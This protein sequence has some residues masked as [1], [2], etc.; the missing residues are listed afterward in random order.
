[1]GTPALTPTERLERRITQLEDQMSDVVRHLEA[2]A[3]LLRVRKE[4]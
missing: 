2:I 1:M 4:P 3:D